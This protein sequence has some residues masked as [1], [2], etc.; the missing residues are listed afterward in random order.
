MVLLPAALSFANCS[1]FF[2]NSALRSKKE[3]ALTPA[4]RAL[5]VGAMV[6]T[7]SVLPIQKDTTKSQAKVIT[8]LDSESG[9]HVLRTR[10]GGFVAVASKSMSDELSPYAYVKTCEIHP[11][12][13]FM[14]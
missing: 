2:A 13:S 3:L 4:A 1:S 14:Y 5:L 7:Q 10:H 12:D 9:C 8:V 11:A 6:V